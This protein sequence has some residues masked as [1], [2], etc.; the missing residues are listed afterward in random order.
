MVTRGSSLPAACAP[1]QKRRSAVKSSAARN[2]FVCFILQVLPVE[3]LGGLVLG[4]G[5]RRL[6]NHS[7]EGGVESQIN[8]MNTESFAIAGSRFGS[9]SRFRSLNGRAESLEH[10][11][12][13]PGESNPVSLRC[14]CSVRFAIVVRFLC[15]SADSFAHQASTSLSPAASSPLGCR[16][17]PPLSNASHCRDR[18]RLPLAHINENHHP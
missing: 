4:C 16:S 18:G 8:G 12:C 7:T 14:A 10:G 1:A 6:W 17:V 13:V 11:R 9:G 3:R 15:R 2:A 5:L